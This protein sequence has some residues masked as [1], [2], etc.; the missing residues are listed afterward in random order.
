[1]F[2]AS[3]RQRL[4]LSRSQTSQPFSFSTRRRRRDPSTH[5]N[6]SFLR[7]AWDAYADSLQRRP[8]PTKCCATALIFFLSDSM[9]QYISHIQHQ[10]GAHSIS[11]DVFVWD[12]W[13]ALSG[14][15]FGIMATTYLHNWWKGL[16]LVC[17]RIMPS[18]R[19]KLAHTFV[20][21]I[22]DQGL[23]APMYIFA[24]YTI[25]NF[26]LLVG[27]SQVSPHEAWIESTTKASAMWW[28]TMQRH[29]RLWPIVHFFNFYYVPL[30]HRVLIQNLVLVGWSGYLSH[31]N[32]GGLLI[33]TIAS[34]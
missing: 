24:Y 29:W 31:L 25:T 12:V 18:T 19:S 8:L 30:Q 3:I 34:K 7:R 9:T 27:E 26:L 1:M 22:I 20:K 13:R 6:V 17:E 15:I 23:G 5:K 2:S 33:P 21:V 28:T 4:P 14:A 32:H 10:H 16:E 11:N